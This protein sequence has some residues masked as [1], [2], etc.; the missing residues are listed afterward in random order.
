VGS[1]TVEQV[2]GRKEWEG[3]HGPMVDYKLMLVGESEEVQL[4]QK[5]STAPPAPGLTLNG[6]VVQQ[7]G[8]RKFKKEQQQAGGR[9][10]GGR[11]PA[12]QAAILRQGAQTRAINYVL[13]LNQLGAIPSVENG[14]WPLVQRIADSMCEDVAAYVKGQGL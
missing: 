9:G 6:E 13:M 7:N 5:P 14:Y 1:F 4:T 8:F 10:G 11:S 12:E 2:V 3:Q